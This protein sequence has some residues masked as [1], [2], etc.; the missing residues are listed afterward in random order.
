MKIKSK[1]MHGQASNPDGRLEGPINDAFPGSG[2]QMGV[3][4][5][6]DLTLPKQPINPFHATPQ[7]DPG[8]EKLHEIMNAK[9]V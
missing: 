8:M 5:D 4:I 3:R 7:T 1:N 9:E 2:R 6:A